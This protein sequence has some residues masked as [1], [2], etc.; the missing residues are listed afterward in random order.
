MECKNNRNGNGVESMDIDEMAT[1]D[2][3]LMVSCDGGGGKDGAESDGGSSG[4]Q[5]SEL[6]SDP[7]SDTDVSFYFSSYLF[8]LSLAYSV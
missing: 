5:G 6:D 8:L 1:E 7:E 2:Q 3:E 4:E